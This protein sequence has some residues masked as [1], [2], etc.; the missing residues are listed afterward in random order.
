MPYISEDI[1]REIRDKVS[2]LQVISP[3]VKLKK[4][5]S[6]FVGLCPFHSE[7]TPS[8]TVHEGK[9][10]F[11]CFGCGAGGNVFTFL[12]KHSHMSFPEAAEDLARRAGIQLKR[13]APTPGEKRAHEEVERLRAVNTAALR[14]YHRCLMDTPEGKNAMDYLTSRGI[15]APQ[16]S[17]FGLGYAP[18]RW[19][20]LL[21][22]LR[23]KAIDPTLAEK[24]GLLVKKSGGGHYDRFRNRVIFP[25]HDASGRVVGFGGRALQGEEP[26]YLNSPETPIYTKGKILYCLHL[27]RE[28]IMKEDR[29]IIVEGYFDALALHLHGFT[30]AVATLG[31]ALTPDHIALL[32]RLSKNVV[33]VFDPDEGGIRAAVRS[34]GLFLEGEVDARIIRLPGGD[35]PDTFLRAKGREAFASLLRS[36]RPLTDFVVEDCRRRHDATIQGKARAVEE[37]LPLIRGVKNPVERDL[38][39]QK[40]AET[41]GVREE[42]VQE[43][44]RRAPVPRPVARPAPARAAYPRTE[45]FIVWMM[46]HHPESI[47]RVRD[48]GALDQFT[49]PVLKNLGERLVGE[50]EKTPGPPAPDGFMEAIQDE[51]QRSVFTRLA[52]DVDRVAQDAWPQALEEAL[53]VFARSRL[54][55]EKQDLERKLKRAEEEGNDAWVAE[56]LV[57]KIELMKKER[58][59][60][61]PKGKS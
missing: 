43:A 28:A 39:I 8:F 18:N 26:K 50:Y 37:L 46:V 21:A 12:M 15:A 47:P 59:R 20:G 57:Q 35:D 51:E 31:T 44:L 17:S 34:L 22:H 1:L 55:K 30:H 29:A 10:I 2:I 13:P 58:G 56:L 4:T 49:A 42:S 14:F 7:K 9:G 3:F 32:R 61:C 52:V 48:E 41:F 45:E 25:I 16:A 24:A 54:K 23:E 53:G 6:N 38:F 11:H 5:G 19:D 60:Q 36:A 27:A 40:T 33:L